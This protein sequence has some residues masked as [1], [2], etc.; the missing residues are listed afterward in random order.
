M[1]FRFQVEDK[2]LEFLAETIR[3]EYEKGVCVPTEKNSM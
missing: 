3:D 2:L 1:C